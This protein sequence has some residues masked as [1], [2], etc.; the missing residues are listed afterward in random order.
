MEKWPYSREIHL[1]KQ[2]IKKDNLNMTKYIL[3]ILNIWT[4]GGKINMKRV[5]S[6]RTKMLSVEHKFINL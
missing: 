4:D 2:K 3:H 6:S 1:A 5:D